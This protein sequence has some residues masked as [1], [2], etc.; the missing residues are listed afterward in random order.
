MFEK[1]KAYKAPVQ[2]RTPRRQSR[3]SQKTHCTMLARPYSW[4]MPLQVD[5]AVILLAE[6]NEN[7]V[8]MLRRAFKRANFLNPLHV[9]ENGDETIAY[10]K[11]EGKYGNR[12]E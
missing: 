9:V 1:L 3:T 6:D 8:L 2:G 12:A 5:E 4:T 10:L 7:D 11:G